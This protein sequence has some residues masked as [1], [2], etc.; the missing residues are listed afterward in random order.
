[1]LIVCGMFDWPITYMSHLYHGLSEAGLFQE[2]CKRIIMPP[3]LQKMYG[4]GYDM[5]YAYCMLRFASG[6]GLLGSYLPLLTFL[7]VKVAS[8]AS[9]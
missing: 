6:P 4:V 1:M 3:M 8:T 7:M 2:C 9:E 5:A